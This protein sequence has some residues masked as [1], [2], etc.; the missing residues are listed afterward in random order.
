MKNPDL[1]FALE[2]IP[3]EG[4]EVALTLAP[5]QVAALAAE[6][7]REQPTIISQLT[8]RLSLRN[9]G[10]NTLRLKGHFTV[11]AEITCDRCLVES[12]ARL[13]AEI[14]ERLELV[15]QGVSRNLDD[16]LDGSLEV[17]DG[18]ID[19]NHLIGELFWLAWPYRHICKADCAG[20]CSK[21]GA[22]LNEG[23]CGCGGKNSGFQTH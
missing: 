19:L 13:S 3:A 12:A 14:D 21:C 22:N 17:V 18:R 7:G 20:L 5:E 23:L 15:N 6:E 2:D 1:I 9:L 8:G 11:T 10:G 16:E 4:L